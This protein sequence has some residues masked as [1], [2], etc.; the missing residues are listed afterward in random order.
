MPPRALP[1]PALRASCSPVAPA[2]ARLGAVAR[3]GTGTGTHVW[4]HQVQVRTLLT[5][6]ATSFWATSYPPQ[7]GK[8]GSSV[9]TLPSPAALPP[10]PGPISAV[11]QEDTKVK[12]AADGRRQM[13]KQRY[14]DSLMD[15]SGEVGLKC[16]YESADSKRQGGNV[17][18]MT[19]RLD[20]RR[21]R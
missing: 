17:L 14:L 4:S 16:E 2:P 1:L 18:L 11:T 20:S 5:R 21:G 8:A 3:T 6:R 7:P 13:R 10:L 12:G 9:P 19:P 15:K